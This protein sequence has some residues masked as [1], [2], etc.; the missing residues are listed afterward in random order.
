[1]SGFDIFKY[2]YTLDLTF[3][4][5][6]WLEEKEFG[7]FELLVSVVLTQNTNWKNVLKALENLKKANISSLEQLKNLEDKELALLI[8]PSGFYN[9]KAKRI[10][11]LVNAILKDYKNLECFKENVSREWLLGIKGLGFESADSIL[12][13]LC[14][15]EILVVDA[16]TNRLALALNYEFLDYEELREFFESGIEQNQDKICKILGKK[17]ELYT[18][19]QIFHALIISFVKTYFKGSKITEQGK[20]IL[21]NIY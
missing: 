8:K 7:D 9:T 10:K 3:S 12:N 6:E 18:I 19:Y 20:E 1:M 14:K 2:L 16:Y 17:C 15:R 5:F 4:D 21:K 13:Y 11:T